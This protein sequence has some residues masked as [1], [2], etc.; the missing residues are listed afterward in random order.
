MTGVHTVGIWLKPKHMCG[1][2]VA[3]TVG[4]V[5]NNM[6]SCTP[7]EAYVYGLRVVSKCFYDHMSRRFPTTLDLTMNVE[8]VLNR[9]SE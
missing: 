2:H 8:V 4:M 9:I 3:D 1:R 7:E 6:G 5:K